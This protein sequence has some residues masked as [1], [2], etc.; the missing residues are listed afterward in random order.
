MTHTASLIAGIAL[1]FKLEESYLNFLPVDIQ[2]PLAEVHADGGL[3]SAGELPGAEA[4]CEAGLAHP[5]V[6][7]HQHFEGPAA[8]QRRRQAAQRAGELQRGL[9][10]DAVVTGNTVRNAPAKSNKC[11]STACGGTFGENIPRGGNDVFL[12]PEAP[13]RVDGTEQR[14]GEED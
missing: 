9:H 10:A 14:G 1:M 2:N 3:H 6:S 4:V 11:L 13:R 8:A 7:D 5:G 12:E